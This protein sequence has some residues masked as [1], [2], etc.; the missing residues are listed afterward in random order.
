[1]FRITKSSPNVD[2]SQV[3]DRVRRRVV[4]VALMDVTAKGRDVL[5]CVRLKDTGYLC[6]GVGELLR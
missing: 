6:N 2:A 1:M 3:Q 4:V 5:A